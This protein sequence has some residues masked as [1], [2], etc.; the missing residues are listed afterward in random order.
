MKST[1]SLIILLLFLQLGYGQQVTAGADIETVLCMLDEVELGG[2]APPIGTTGTWT[3]IEGPDNLELSNPNDPNA[4]IINEVTGIFILEWRVQGEGPLGFM[5]EADTMQLF[6][7]EDNQPTADAGPDIELICGNSVQLSASSLTWPSF[8]Y[9]E[10]ISGS[11]ILTDVNAPTSLVF[12]LQE[13]ANIFRW[14]AI[15]SCSESWDE[16]TVFYY[17]FPSVNAGPN[18]DFCIFEESLQLPSY[19]SQGPW[20]SVWTGPG[21]SAQGLF[22]PTTTGTFTLTLT[23]VSTGTCS[24]SDQMTVTVF[25]GGTTCQGAGCTDPS[26][27][28]FDSTATIDNG[29]CSFIS[30]G[31]LDCNGDI[32]IEDMLQLIS[33]YGCINADDCSIFD[34]NNDGVVGAQDLLILLENM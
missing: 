32:T 26:A 13:G 2:S 21:V 3:Q 14:N 12:G 25:D 24:F 31:D 29:T 22:T 8:G 9:W 17:P 34:L 7:Y 27:C 18:L 30:S 4:Q 33:N 5:N 16:V 15:T 11:G 1:L 19:P 20:S 28:N 10:V 6:I 23:Y